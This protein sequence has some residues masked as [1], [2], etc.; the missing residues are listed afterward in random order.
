MEVKDI[1]KRKSVITAIVKTDGETFQKMIE[2]ERI[3]VGW[4]RWRVYE[5]FYFQQC[6]NCAGF[7]HLAKDCKSEA[8]CPRCASN[9]PL[10]ECNASVDKCSNCVAVNKSLKL[11]VPTDHPAWSRECSVYLR[12]ISV[13]RQKIKYSK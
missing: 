6:Y 12:K 10:K 3:Y 11:N 7:H 8:S 2:H 4:D 5:H 13:E 9:H 1:S